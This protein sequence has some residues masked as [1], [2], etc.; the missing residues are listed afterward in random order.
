MNYKGRDKTA[1]TPLCS[2]LLSGLTNCRQKGTQHQERD[3]GEVMLDKL[4]AE[5]DDWKTAHFL[6]PFIEETLFNMTPP[7]EQPSCYDTLIAFAFGNRPNDSGDPNQLAKPGPMNKVLADCCAAFYRRNPVPMYV[8]WEIA[9]YLNGGGYADIPL[10]HVISIEPYWDDQGKLIY[11]STDGVAEVIVN[12]YFNGHPDAIGRA[13]IIGHGDHVKRCIMTCRARGI[14]SS[15]A[16]SIQL[17]Y[18]YDEQSDQPWTRRRELY[19]LQDMATRLLMLAQSN[20][21]QAYPPKQ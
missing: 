13:A 9:R 11:L 20:I 10:R 8:Q 4:A 7:S 2:S 16:Q 17:P 18:W 12:R 15:A 3:F 21:S 14:N 6:A 19:L 5:L 1:S